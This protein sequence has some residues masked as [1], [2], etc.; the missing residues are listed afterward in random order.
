MALVTASAST[1]AAA[2]AARATAAAPPEWVRWKP[3][4]SKQR[5]KKPAQGDSFEALLCQHKH[6]Q[7]Q[8]QQQNGLKTSLKKTFKLGI[9]LW[10]WKNKCNQQLPRCQTSPT[11][12]R[13][14]KKSE[15]NQTVSICWN[16]TCGVNFCRRSATLRNST[17]ALSQR[18]L[19]FCESDFRFRKFAPFSPKFCHEIGCVSC[20]PKLRNF[21]A[22]T[23]K[24]LVFE[25]NETRLKNDQLHWNFRP[26]H[27][28]G[29]FKK[30][31]YQVAFK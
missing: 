25:K 4:P 5:R 17:T 31:S 10:S 29:N 8:Q 23:E 26:T 28:K 20:R 16:Q 11:V 21:S 30:Y 15:S 3:P 12:D 19:L 9:S 27:C 13:Q 2:A 1:A 14:F 24:N 7:Q 18:K 6:R 22:S